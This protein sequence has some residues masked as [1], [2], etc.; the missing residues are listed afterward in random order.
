MRALIYKYKEM[1]LYLFFGGCTTIVNICVYALATRIF[2]MEV[3]I[4][5]VLAW[6]VSVAF[7]YFTNR[8][9]VFG[10]KVKDFKGLLK[11]II[12]FVGCRF[13]SGILDLLMMWFFVDVLGLR[14]IIIKVTA[15]IVVIIINF[16]TS[17]LWIFKNK[18]FK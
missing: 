15:N 3:V 6:V 16:L 13:F 11:E 10:S 5:T 12:G 1:I 17:K 14:D 2:S 9:Y 18:D 8:I 7:A 4:A